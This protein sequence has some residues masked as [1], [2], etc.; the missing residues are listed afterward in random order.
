M[1]FDN[2]GL[3]KENGADDLQDS[4][5]LAGLLS[6]FHI[7][8]NKID[9]TL[10]IK[11]KRYIRHPNE[12]IYDFS[13]DQALCLMA[14]LYAQRLYHL[15]DLRLVT[16]H[17][18]FSPSH[19]GH[20][21]RCQNKKANW[22]ENLWLKAEILYQAKFKPLNEPNQLLCMMVVAGVDYLKIWTDNNPQWSEAIINYWCGWR[23][24]PQLAAELIADVQYAI[25]PAD[26]NS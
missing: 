4:A 13:R 9:L 2:L 5:R 7:G 16:G 11:E 8:E 17:D 26:E 1:I 3:P 19:R 23:G 10:Y 18:I 20:V 12:Y 6:V 24:E 14:G 25:T 15:V 22:F 21:K